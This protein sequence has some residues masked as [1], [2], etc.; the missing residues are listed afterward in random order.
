[1]SAATYLSASPLRPWTQWW[2]FLRRCTGGD[3]G[4][5]GRFSAAMVGLAAAEPR[6][7]SRTAQEASMTRLAARSSLSQHGG[8]WSSL[9]LSCS[10]SWQRNLRWP[11]RRP[12]RS[13]RSCS[14]AARRWPFTLP[15]L[16][17]R[18]Q[19]A[20]TPLSQ[21]LNASPT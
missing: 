2:S 19:P 16:H 15:G 1:M 13:S 18:S 12:R 20:P 7:F 3:R 21:L 14:P 11:R 4:H 6:K 9:S 10:P 17:F 5:M 8:Y